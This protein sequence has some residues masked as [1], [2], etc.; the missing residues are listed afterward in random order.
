MATIDVKDAAGTTVAIEKPLAPGRAAA[1]ASRPVVIANEDFAALGATNETAA[2]SDTATSGLNGRLQ[3][4]A[5]RLTSLIALV[6]ASLGQKA[7]AASLA[8][9]LASDEDLL[10]RIGEVQASP[11]SNTVLDRLKSL[12]TGIV[13]AAGSA[14]IGKVDHTTTGIGHGVTNV[15]TAGTDVAL[16]SSTPAKWVVIMARRTNTANIAVG[17]SGVDATAST[18]NGVTLAAGESI[19]LPVDNLADV[20]IDATV[21]GEGVRYT[22]G[23]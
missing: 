21:N 15:T 20:Y 8:V 23:T 22:Y 11:T 7:K 19:T 13:L 18:G 10:G 3:R 2:S 12:L 17:G 9:T 1:S 5:Q 4:I 6:P 14:V 16:A